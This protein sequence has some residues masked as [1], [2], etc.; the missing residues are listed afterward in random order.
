MPLANAN[1]ADLVKGGMPSATLADQ[2]AG[3]GKKRILVDLTATTPSKHVFIA[4]R[5]Y[6]VESI[7]EIH[8]V[9]G[10]AS[11]NCKLRRI[12][13]TSAPGAAASATV[14]EFITAG[15]DLTTTINTVVTGTLATST[16]NSGEKLS[17]LMGGTLTGLVGTVVVT[18]APA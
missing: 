8:S 10:G 17:I 9:V 5:N 18:L 4:D 2:V 15:L 1:Q 3:L 11:A 14:V 12:T 13:D 7:Q 16:L 6:T